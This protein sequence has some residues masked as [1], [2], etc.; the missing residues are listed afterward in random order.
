MYYK[1]ESY[2]FV[3]N[4]DFFAESKQKFANVHNAAWPK[5]LPTFK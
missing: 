2:R 4:I 1:S 5:K 3:F